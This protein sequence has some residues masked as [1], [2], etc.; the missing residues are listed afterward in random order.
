M[1]SEASL[2]RMRGVI[3]MRIRTRPHFEMSRFNPDGI[4]VLMRSFACVGL[5]L[6]YNELLASLRCKS[7]YNDDTW[8]QILR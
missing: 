5:T 8:Q 4:C 7:F 1:A 3:L 2:L 6:C